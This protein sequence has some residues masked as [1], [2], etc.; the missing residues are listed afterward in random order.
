[1]SKAKLHTLV[2]WIGATDLNVA[3]S[4]AE[5]KVF[6]SIAETLKAEFFDVVELFYNYPEYQVKSY[7][8]WL[9]SW[10]RIPP[11]FNVLILVLVMLRL[12]ESLS[13]YLIFYS[14]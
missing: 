2:S 4:N 7:L 1:M 10:Y 11:R 13:E 12:D 5:R 8:L 6:S 14:S 3:S 9:Q